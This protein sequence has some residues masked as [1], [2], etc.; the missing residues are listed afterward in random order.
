MWGGVSKSGS[1][2]L[3][4]ITS[5]PARRSSSARDETATVEEGLRLRARRESRKG[6]EVVMGRGYRGPGVTR[7]A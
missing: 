4:L 5:T 7:N 1:P 3:M 2:T 6:E